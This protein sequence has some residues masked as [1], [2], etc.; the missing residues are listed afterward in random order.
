MNDPTVYWQYYDPILDLPPDPHPYVWKGL[1]P[2]TEHASSKTVADRILHDLDRNPAEDTAYLVQKYA[3]AAHSLAQAADLLSK[4]GFPN[5]AVECALS[6]SQ[7]A[8]QTRQL[9][10]LP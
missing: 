9:T 7:L 4:C 3:D 10:P 8:F 2:M 1:P 6:A 5:A